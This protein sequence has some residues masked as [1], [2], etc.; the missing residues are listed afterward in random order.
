MVRILFPLL[1]PSYRPVGTGDRAPSRHTSADTPSRLDSWQ[2]SPCVPT[3]R[4]IEILLA[5]SVLRREFGLRSDRL[6]ATLSLLSFFFLSFPPSSSMSDISPISLD[7]WRHNLV[8]RSI[9]SGGFS[10]RRRTFLH[11]PINSLETRRTS[12]RGKRPQG[13]YPKGVGV[14]G[15][16]TK[17]RCR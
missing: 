4:I 16:K 8:D 15:E 7:V 6:L 14:G 13:L 3:S 5:S 2:S 9:V 11:L 17:K 1:F 10:R 12:V